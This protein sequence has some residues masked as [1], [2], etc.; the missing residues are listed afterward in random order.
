[1]ASAP[2]T[3]ALPLFYKDLAPIN[4]E[5]HANLRARRTDKATW[6]VDQ[7]AIPLT[8]EEFVA[9]QRHFPI[10]FSIGDNA[11]PLG[12]FGMNEGVNVFVGDDGTVEDGIYV[13]AYARRY[14]FLLAKLQPE[15]QELS[16]CFDPTGDLIGELED[17]E[18][19]FENGQ[20]TE[21]VQKA[22]AFCEQFEIAGNKTATFIQELQKHDLL[23]DAELSFK[24]E[25]MDQPI[26][27]RGFRMVSE[28]KLRDLRGDVLRTWNKNGMLPLI[29]AHLYS[30]ELVNTIFA[31][32]SK[33]GKLPQL[34]EPA[35]AS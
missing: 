28:E 13:P 15:A 2:Q 25:D 1:M 21:Y 8:V 12:L 27:Y 5:D 20:P 11:V 9:C 24:R 17:G 7:H 6:L 4:L 3:N 32:Q 34:P 10:V 22:L 14:P 29:F 30:L 23:M 16:L 18:P 19:L 31:R 35:E 33:Q 26:V